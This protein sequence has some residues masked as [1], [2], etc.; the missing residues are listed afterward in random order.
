[1]RSGTSGRLVVLLVVLAA[2]ALGAGGFWLISAPAAPIDQAPSGSVVQPAS[3]AASPRNEA[4]GT[5]TTILREV[6]IA[7]GTLAR[8]V[9]RP[10][11]KDSTATPTNAPTPVDEP[12]LADRV[13]PG[14]RAV[15][16]LYLPA[17]GAPPATSGEKVNVLAWLPPEDQTPTATPTGDPVVL[18]ESV[19]VIDERPGTSADAPRQAMLA[20]SPLEAQILALARQYGVFRLVPAKAS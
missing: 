8:G 15:T 6:A 4:S 19:L 10:G 20:V 5:P 13:P 12:R 18:V 9:F 7:A 2:L 1:M 17:N 3:S 16:V 11:G 14:R